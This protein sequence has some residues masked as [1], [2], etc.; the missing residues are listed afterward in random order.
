MIPYVSV[1]GYSNS[2]KTLL[3]RRLVALLT[4][5]GYRVA[6]VKHASKGY[7]VDTPGK[8]SWHF[9][10]QGAQEVIVVGQ[11]A[12]TRHRRVEEEPNL[13][14]LLPTIQNVDIIL[15]EGFK[16]YPGPK[17]QVFRAGHSSGKLPVT[18]EVI[19]MVAEPKTEHEVPCFSFD[20]MEQLAKFIISCF[21]TA[22]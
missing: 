13:A 20:E 8:D 16:N 19:A 17:I 6:A 2:G 18:S 4:G 10:Q 11:G 7:E 21:L 22:E 15:V 1:V 12:Y 3:T 9:F 5:K 14:D